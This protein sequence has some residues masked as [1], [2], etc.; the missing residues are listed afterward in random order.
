M[1]FVIPGVLALA[2]AAV[3]ALNRRIGQALMLSTVG[4]LAAVVVSEALVKAISLPGPAHIAVA[5]VIGAGIAWAYAALPLVG[6]F[7]SVLSI[8]V[9]AFP[10]LFLLDPAMRSFVQPHDRTE[11]AAVKLGPTRPPIVLAIFDQLPLTSLLSDDDTIDAAQ[12]P[13]FASLA[14]DATWYRNA[15]TSAELTGWAI[16]TILTGLLPRRDALPTTQDFPDNLFT[17]LNTKYHYEAE[18]PITDLCPDRLCTDDLPPLTDR[19]AGMVVDSGVVV[20]HVMT[21]TSYEL[22]LPPLTE[23]WRN[24]IRDQ[25]VGRRWV[26][27]RDQ[28]RRIGPQEWIDGIS[29]AD[30]QPTLYYLHALLPHEPYIYLPTGQLIADGGRMPALTANGHWAR[31]EWAVAQIYQRHLLQV[32]YVDRLVG[33]MVARLKHEGL[34]DRALVV[35]TADHGVSFRPGRWYKEVEGATLPDIMCVPLFVKLP[36]QHGGGISDRNVQSI[37]VLPTI[38]DVLHVSLPWQTDGRSA[39]GDPPPSLKTIRYFGATQSRDIETAELAGLRREAV[40]RRITMFD[41]TDPDLAPRIGVHRELV[42]QPLSALSLVDEAGP[43]VSIDGVDRFLDFD[44]D[45]AKVGPRLDGTVYDAKGAPMAARLAVSVNGI[46]CATTRTYQF[47][48]W[49]AGRWQVFIGPRHFKKGVN[50]VRVFVINDGTGSVHLDQ[51]YALDAPATASTSL[52]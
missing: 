4:L 20:A 9:V 14:A 32:R 40:H 50:R 27:E 12:Y 8:G 28:D 18:E 6:S 34:W 35:V 25:Q 22:R 3:T 17:A 48:G 23:D 47:E 26:S 42:G 33:E 39:L 29:G 15:S 30:P 36:G 49:P 11:R 19:L 43:T 37:D 13:G 7:V 41:E 44:P 10:V 24:F 45:A 51:A 1:S 21:P 52:N 5:L 2:I 38:A 46:V 31:D 16:P